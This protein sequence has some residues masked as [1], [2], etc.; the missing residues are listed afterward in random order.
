MK[1][2]TTYDL[3][4]RQRE[5]LDEVSNGEEVYIVRK[6]LKFRLELLGHVHEILVP[7]DKRRPLQDVSPSMTIGDL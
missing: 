6:G 5:I 7:V 4:T 2:Y 1:T 3:H